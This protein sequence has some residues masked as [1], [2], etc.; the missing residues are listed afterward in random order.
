MGKEKADLIHSEDA[1]DKASK[2][3][4]KVKEMERNLRE[5]LKT[6]ILPNGVQITSNKQE[7]IN[8]YISNYGKL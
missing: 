7:I 6:I 3:L 4:E 8:D 2:G 1:M 5:R